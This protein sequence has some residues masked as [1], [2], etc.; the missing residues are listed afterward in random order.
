MDGQLG[1]RNGSSSQTRRTARNFLMFHQIAVSLSK[2]IHCFFVTGEDNIARFDS[3]RY[4][5]VTDGGEGGCVWILRKRKPSWKPKG[6][7]RQEREKAGSWL[8]TVDE[9]RHSRMAKDTGDRLATSSRDVYAQSK[10]Y[11]ALCSSY[12]V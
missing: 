1:T 4:S 10:C 8:Q 2:Y 9:D 6:P 5:I 11:C 7:A 3:Q 12:T